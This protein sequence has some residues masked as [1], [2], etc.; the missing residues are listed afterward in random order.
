MIFKE[1]N[2]SNKVLSKYLLFTLIALLHFSVDAQAQKMNVKGT[3]TG[4]EDGMPIPG[5]TVL[6]KGT[7]K[8]VSTDFDGNYAI[9]ANTGDVLVY[10]FLGMKSKSVS[11]TKAVINVSLTSD[12]AALEEVVVVGYGTVRKKELTGS[13]AQVKADQI[14]EFSTPDLASALQGQISGVN[15]A[16]SSGE[17]G[18]A[19][20][21]QIRGLSSLLGSNEPLYVVD[22]IAQTGNPGLSP[23]EIETIDVLKDA[24]SAA[25]YGSSAAAGVILITTKRGEEGRMNVSINSKYGIQTLGDGIELMNTAEELFFAT[26][27]LDNGASSYIPGPV[28]Y[29]EWL[30]NNNTFDDFVLVDN[31]ATN[32][33]TVNISGGTKKF[34]YNAVGGY[35]NQQ[36]AI[37]NSGFTRINGRI[38]TSYNSDNWKFNTSLA[39]TT[40]D[41]QRV[42]TN[43][44]ANAQR[45]SPSY[46]IVDTSSDIIYST[47]DGGDG[48]V[49]TPLELLARALK[50]QDNS[51]RDRIN[52]SLSV[53]RK[54]TE[55]LSFIGNIGTAITDDYRNQF[56]PKYT[57]VFLNGDP[58]E[59]DPVK[60][61]VTV[62]SSRATT[63][64][65]DGTLRFK[66]KIDDHNFGAQATFAVKEGTYEG[67]LASKQGVLNNSV[68]TL[69]GTSINPVVDALNNYKYTE[70]GI[71]GRF[72]YDYKGKYLISSLFRRD[73]S[74]RFSDNDKWGIFPS[75]SAAWNVSDE[76]FWSP[77]KGTVNNFKIRASR[78]SVGNN[79]F[80]DYA[81][82]STIQ[83]NANYI[84]DTTDAQLSQGTAIYSYANPNVKWETK[85]EN[86][87]GVDLGFFK[88][89][90]SLTVDYYKSTNE[91]MLFPVR[92]PG[93]AGAYDGGNV[94]T[95][96]NVGNME[97]EGFEIAAKYRT[98]IG[99]SK[100]NTSL[101]F[102]KNKN[103][104]TSTNGQSII[105]N[106][107]S[108]I[109]SQD[110]TVFAEGY[111][112]GAFW[113][114]QA[115]GAINTD[116]RLAAYQLLN[117]AAKMGDMEYLDVNN[118]GKL[119]TNDRKY[120]GSGM[121]DFEAGFN[122]NWR[123]KGFDFGMNWFASIGAEIINGNKIQAY[124]YGRHRDLLNMWSADNPNS[125]I[126]IHRDVGTNNFEANS[127]F[128]VENGDYIRLKLV[129][130][131]YT[132]PKKSVQ[133]LGLSNLRVYLT[134]QNPLTITD[135]TGYDP[136]IGGSVM[137]RGL[138]TSRYPVSALYTVG[139][140]VK[141]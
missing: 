115:N 52:A 91:D 9:K 27:Q 108:R 119:D 135:Y 107:S 81:A 106:T 123:Y 71:L 92:V 47:E 28:K 60:S 87:I 21:V 140:N 45:Y 34:S 121:P 10:S 130:L 50:K 26:T 1:L 32:Q 79:R 141:F 72:T 31:A 137:R 110:M 57:I 64:S 43:L 33:H 36:G 44:I 3:V 131:G 116:E 103:K 22:G 29:P 17:P 104:V 46:P 39:F 30:N 42:G 68:E 111:E 24:A 13:V 134:A 117:P 113:L 128:W 66:K 76:D 114:Y 70:V 99:K 6:I 118:D 14:E 49:R 102:S 25:V 63:L 98:D 80:S 37:I 54:I 138:D 67:F 58:S 109:N 93:S 83:T 40:E 12:V 132:I 41:R 136:E 69:D 62:T 16:A 97:N 56:Q 101:T 8:G 122:L 88:N 133:K 120:S 105:Y 11:V 73:G 89:K 77:L 65:A 86:N 15:I 82:Q 7:T 78:G 35:F 61:S 85:T 55:D 90:I 96:L 53:T 84:F 20:S 126:P 95:I 125:N 51:K 5:A 94:N 100:L 19:A 23:N 2:I 18:E 4:A 127:N 74:S 124:T 129:S 59:T 139:L 38:T 48:G 112:A 75:I